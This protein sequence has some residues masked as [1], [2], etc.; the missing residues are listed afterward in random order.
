MCNV[1]FI[2]LACSPQG[3]AYTNLPADAIIYPFVCST[4]AKSSLKLINATSIPKTLQ[5]QCMHT[6][7]R[8]PSMVKV[9]NLGSVRGYRH[10]L[11]EYL[12][13]CSQTIKT[14]PGFAALYKATWFLRC[15]EK[16]AYQHAAS[17]GDTTTATTT[18]KPRTLSDVLG[19]TAAAGTDE[20]IDDL[21]R[22]MPDI[23]DIYAD[24]ETDY[25]LEAVDA[26]KVQRFDEEETA[27]FLTD[28]TMIGGVHFL[29]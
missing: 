13:F 3:V 19:S 8:D 29:L 6:L 10:P 11:T 22:A 4:S 26:S 15:K 5:Y 23:D 24:C 7:A 17:A 27:S 20:A 21:V 1:L 18:K 16:F 14:I 28:D 12:Y 2:I 25:Y 9:H